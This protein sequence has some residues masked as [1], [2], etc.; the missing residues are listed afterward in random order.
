MPAFSGEK[1]PLYRPKWNSAF[2]IGTTA[3]DKYTGLNI[4]HLDSRRFLIFY[5][6][7]PKDRESNVFSL[8]TTGQGGGYPSLRFSSPF[9]RLWSQVLS[10]G[11]PVFCSHVPSRGGGLSESCHRSCIGGTPRT[12]GTPQDWGNPLPSQDWGTPPVPG[13]GVLPAPWQ[14]LG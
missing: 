14:G 1:Y 6:P 13:T 12:R 5:R 7:H 4:A 10:G 9:P 2:Q 8:F 3:L 11:T